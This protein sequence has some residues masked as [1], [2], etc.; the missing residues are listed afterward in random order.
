MYTLLISMMWGG[1]IY[2]S[3]SDIGAESWFVLFFVFLI[4][5]AGI[6]YEGY[7]GSVKRMNSPLTLKHFALLFIVMF[8]IVFL[9]YVIDE[10]RALLNDRT[11]FS[12]GYVII[13]AVWSYQIQHAWYKNK[14]I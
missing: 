12:I 6:I 13:G 5:G 8:T 9:F 11:L 7:A 2:V 14:K 10:F 1:L 4:M 3:L